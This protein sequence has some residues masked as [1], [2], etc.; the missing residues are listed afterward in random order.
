MGCE[1]C[2]KSSC[3]RSFHS[4]DEQQ[5]FDSVADGIKERIGRLINIEVNRLSY[6]EID[7]EVYVSL[8][9]VTNIINNIL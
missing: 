3:T 4:L 5:D 6:Q 9:D 8:S 7:S 2:N 1:I